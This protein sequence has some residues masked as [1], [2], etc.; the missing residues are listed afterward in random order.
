MQ[1]SKPTSFEFDD[2]RA[3]LRDLISYLRETTRSFSFRKF[4]RRAG[5]QSPN[6]L[7]LVIDGKRNISEESMGRFAEAFGFPSK[8]ALDFR[9][10]V[11]F[12]QSKTD[13]ERNEN[14]RRL[15][16]TRPGK[17]AELGGAQY[18][19]Y[20]AWY[21]LPIRELATLEQFNEAPEK[22]AHRFIRSV[23]A[24]EA[25]KALKLLQ[26]VGLLVRGAKGNLRATAS[27]LRTGP[28]VPLGVRNFHRAMLDQA[29]AALDGIPKT[30][31]HVSSL[32]QALSREQ[33]EDVCERIDVFREELLE[34]MEQKRPGTSDDAEIYF[35]GFE[36]IPL[37]K[38]L[39]PKNND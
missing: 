17:A 9:N 38:P 26:Q 35:V 21:A 14:Y 6:F 15:R 33:Y 37:T 20:S 24:V 1:A 18:D 12:N 29:K 4:S 13:I 36:V 10:L 7:K 30:K 23:S 31:R 25:R 2:Y 27:S 34:V 22:I 28:E 32:T 19:I 8:E 39:D 5:Y 3:F 16:R 11:R